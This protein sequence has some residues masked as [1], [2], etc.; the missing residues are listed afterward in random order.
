[1]QLH[2][3]EVSLTQKLNGIVEKGADPYGIVEMEPSLERYPLN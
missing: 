2:P 1:M 3:I